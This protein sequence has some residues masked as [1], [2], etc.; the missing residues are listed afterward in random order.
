MGIP[1]GRCFLA[2]SFPP[3]GQLGPL[4]RA[5]A[6]LG[7]SAWGRFSHRVRPPNLTSA[8]CS[9]ESERHVRIR[10]NFPH[11]WGRTYTKRLDLPSPRA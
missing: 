3:A 4:W 11:F 6:E 1:V 7:R 8:E 10:L 5:E 2:G 9:A